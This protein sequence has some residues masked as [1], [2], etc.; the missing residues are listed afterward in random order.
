MRVLKNAVVCH[1]PFFCPTGQAGIVCHQNS[2]DNHSR[3]H[4]IMLAGFV[5]FF[6]RFNHR[7]HMQLVT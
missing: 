7:L 6:Q 3:Q 2:F 4:Q 5:V 1:F